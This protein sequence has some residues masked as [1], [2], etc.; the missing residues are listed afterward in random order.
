MFWLQVST[1]VLYFREMSVLLFWAPA[2]FFLQWESVAIHVNALYL[3]IYLFLLLLI[4]LAQGKFE[5]GVIKS[6]FL[7]SFTAMAP[8]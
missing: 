7:L 6:L 2:F 8:T 5:N 4:F 3:F 1:D